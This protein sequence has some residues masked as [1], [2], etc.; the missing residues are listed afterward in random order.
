[1]LHCNILYLLTIV[2][3]SPSGVQGCKRAQI[4]N[5]QFPE[6]IVVA[7]IAPIAPVARTGHSGSP[8]LALLRFRRH[9][10]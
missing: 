2:S 8:D 5:Y 10:E 6:Q 4:V 7:P 1:M 9:S 3:S